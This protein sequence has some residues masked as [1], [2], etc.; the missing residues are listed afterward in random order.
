M[1]LSRSFFLNAS[2]RC[3]TFVPSRDDQVHIYCNRHPLIC[4]LPKL[5]HCVKLQTHGTGKVIHHL[6]PAS[7]GENP[8]EPF[9]SGRCSVMR[10]RIGSSFNHVSYCRGHGPD[11]GAGSSCPRPAPVKVIQPI[12][13]VGAV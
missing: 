5:V 7:L 1:F 12:R 2:G 10:I 8:V 6:R 11:R 9:V 3:R 4:N 13:T